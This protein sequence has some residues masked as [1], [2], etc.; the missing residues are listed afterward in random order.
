MNSNEISKTESKATLK[1]NIV[2]ACVAFV[3]CAAICILVALLDVYV[4][5]LSFS[6]ETA[7]IL[8]DGFFVSGVLGV[9]FWLLILVSQ[10]GAFDMMV[11]G[12]RKLFNYL[13]KKNPEDS[14]LPHTYYDYVMIK[15]GK[16]PKRFYFFLI[17]AA[18]YLAIGMICSFVAVA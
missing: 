7:R 15:R 10:L 9:L 3:I 5:E 2:S 14:T 1:E 6:V 13:F 4:K 17:V 8:G 16:K 11:Y 18:V 12:C